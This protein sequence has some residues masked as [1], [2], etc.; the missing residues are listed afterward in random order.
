MC[1]CVCLSVSAFTVEPFDVETQNLVEALTLIIIILN[2]FE[3]QGHRSKVKDTRF[4]NVISEVSYGLSFCKPVMTRRHNVTWR[5]A[6]T[7]WCHTMTSLGNNI[8]KEGSTRAIEIQNKG[9]RRS[10]LPK[11]LSRRYKLIADKKTIGFRTDLSWFS[12]IKPSSQIS[13]SI[14]EIRSAS[15]LR[16]WK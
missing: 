10:D 13:F 7:L 16:V 11:F 2:E 4:K 15:T 9:G 6:M 5:H 14:W 3:G 1:V 12:P 8:D